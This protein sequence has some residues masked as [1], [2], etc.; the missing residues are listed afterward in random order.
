MCRYIYVTELD[1]RI[2][3]CH[4]AA[5][6]FKVLPYYVNQSIVNAITSFSL[7]CLFQNSL[8]HP[9][10]DIEYSTYRLLSPHSLLLQVDLFEDYHR[11]RPS[12]LL[13][14]LHST[15]TELV[16]RHHSLEALPLVCLY[17]HVAYAL[18]RNLEHTMRARLLKA[19]ALLQLDL[20]GEATNTVRELLLGIHLPQMFCEF[21]LGF[22]VPSLNVAFHDDLPMTH[23]KNVRAMLA[24]ADKQLPQTLRN[25]YGHHLSF[26]VVLIQ[27]SLL[28][29][30]AA[31]SHNA[32]HEC[33]LLPSRR[34][35][36]E[37]KAPPSAPPSA[38]S[39]ATTVG[40]SPLNASRTAKSFDL[41]LSDL[42]LFLLE[43][44]EN[45][46]MES[47]QYYIAECGQGNDS[48]ICTAN[49]HLSLA[50]P[51]EL[52]QA[53]SFLILADVALLHHHSLS[54]AQLSL[55]GLRVL[56][57]VGKH[58]Q[59]DLPLWMETKIKLA[60]SLALMQWPMKEALAGGMQSQFNCSVVC[61]QGVRESEA[62]GDLETSALLCYI[63]ATH[64]L[65]QEPCLTSEVARLA[66]SCLDYLERIPRLSLRGKLVK[67]RASLLLADVSCVT[68]EGVRVEMMTVYQGIEQMLINQVRTIIIWRQT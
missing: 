51:F 20:F 34:T 1:A 32:L 7:Q 23:A 53:K 17:E 30:M 8:S 55:S 54:A 19:E 29:K 45:L 14:S 39:V 43:S 33:N 50:F 40:Q 49:V 57:S 41:S 4:L 62:C 2:E 58:Y 36:D 47:T 38:P 28:T 26:D 59:G 66:Q 10:T 31:T 67:A 15:A 5:Q 24:V 37:D 35:D 44:V 25:A 11:C 22:E 9:T 27:C 16:H 60:E 65:L 56:Q 18:A 64:L 42:N 48:Y 52:Y 61:E 46:I 63:N 12:L 6:F 13:A 68:G 3:S 21:E